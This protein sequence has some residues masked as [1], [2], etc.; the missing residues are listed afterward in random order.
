MSHKDIREASKLVHEKQRQEEERKK[1]ER[2]EEFESLSGE[3]SD[4]KKKRME[5]TTMAINKPPLIDWHSRKFK[6]AV[7]VIVLCLLAIQVFRITTRKQ[8]IPSFAP[9]KPVY[10]YVEKDNSEEVGKYIQKVMDS[11]VK[12]G[13]KGLEGFW[14]DKLP[15]FVINSSYLY[16]PLKVL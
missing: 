10:S 5:E 4:R 15:Q 14:D 12:N 3:V 8:E 1:A 9:Y 6:I 7:L 16:C 11:Y 13:E 2:K